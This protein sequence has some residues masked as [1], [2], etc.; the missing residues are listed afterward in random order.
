MKC[1]DFINKII[2]NDYKKN[3]EQIQNLIQIGNIATEFHKQS[4]TLTDSIK[5]KLEILKNCD[6][7]LIIEI[8]HQPNY[9]PYYGVW[10]KAIFANYLSELL[11]K[12]KIP[13]VVLFGLVDQDTSMSPF[14]YKNK[15]PYYSKEGFK[16]IGYKIKGENEWWREWCKQPLPP[17]DEIEKQHDF[18]MNLYIDNGLS[19]NDK[20]IVIMEELLKECYLTDCTFSE[21]NSKFF[22]IVCNRIFN[23]NIVFFSY[24]KA[25]KNNIF[26]KQFESLLSKRKNYV[27]IYNQIIERE[28]LDL[29]KI[30]KDHIPFWYHCGCGGKIR[31]KIDDE[32]S[33]FF[34]TCPICN[35]FFEKK[36]DINYDLSTI[37]ESISFE[38]VSR[39]LIVP[40]AIGTDVYIEGSGGSLSFRK[41][42]N[43]IARE[44][45]F[46]IPVA[47][48]WK[49]KDKYVSLMLHK[50]IKL[51]QKYPAEAIDYELSNSRNKIDIMNKEI[52][53]LNDQ[54]KTLTDELK[55]YEYN[56]IEFKNNL[57]LL[58]NVNVKKKNI[59]VEL[60]KI[61]SKLEKS[62]IIMN[63]MNQTP[64]ILDEVLSAG[65][66]NV[67]RIWLSDL[68]ENNF[69]N[70]HI[71][72]IESKKIP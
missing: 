24:S 63:A 31:I 44:M 5:E 18:L 48:G 59:N 25:Q 9:L 65:F 34:G 39:E 67:L 56:S 70:E 38:A 35:F 71:I 68:K 32:K 43:V 46:N 13:T 41:I 22:S 1:E 28:K 20:D 69:D 37:Y 19:K 40:T 42:S 49:S 17:R 12:E 7:Y 52:A 53:E 60:T 23:T 30:A 11:D 50:L 29:E 58:K 21:A 64:S 72:N 14:L 4:K 51:E 3:E 6:N 61:S 26:T 27:N 47:I 57:E 45:N 54:H 8:A 33:I 16:N 62:Q 55:K 15:I 10:K 2:N 36:N 66:D